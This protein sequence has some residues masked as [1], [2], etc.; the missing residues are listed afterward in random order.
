MVEETAS[1][2]QTYEATLGN[3]PK[4]FKNGRSEGL[5]KASGISL[6]NPDRSKGI[7][8]IEYQKVQTRVAFGMSDQGWITVTAHVPAQLMLSAGGQLCTSGCSTAVQLSTTATYPP[9][10]YKY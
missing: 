7:A 8:V 9:T 4:T 5:S 1:G 10:Y 3:S 6:T 2:T